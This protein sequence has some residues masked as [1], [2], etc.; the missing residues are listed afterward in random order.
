MKTDGIKLSVKLV[1]TVSRMTTFKQV[2][3]ENLTQQLKEQEE[4]EMRKKEEGR[5]DRNCV[6]VSKTMT[7]P[8]NRLTEKEMESVTSVFKSFE[9]GL[10]GAT[11]SS[12][13]PPAYSFFLL[14]QMG[15]KFQDL[16]F[17]M[18]RLGLNPTEQE[19]VDIP[20]KIGRYLIQK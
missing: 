15:F 4:K 5:E 17:A 10:R 7:N 20:N 19:T 11:I 1:C 6:K 2:E 13:V 8:R 16:P 12:R 3:Y 14:I 9:T 18:K